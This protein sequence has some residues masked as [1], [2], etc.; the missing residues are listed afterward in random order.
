MSYYKPLDSCKDI[1]SV[2]SLVTGCTKSLSI[3]RCR[4][5]LFLF[6][7]MHWWHLTHWFPKQKKQKL[8]EIRR[9]RENA[10]VLVCSLRHRSN[11]A[12]F[13]L[14]S[15]CFV[16][17]L[18]HQIR[19]MDLEARSLPPSIKSSLLVKL[20][21][22]S[23]LISTTSKAKSRD[24][25]GQLIDWVEPQTE[26]R[27]WRAWRLSPPRLAQSETVFLSYALATRYVLSSTIFSYTGFITKNTT[28]DWHL[29]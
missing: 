23:S 28:C 4:S 26:S 5:S 8:S 12:A 11:K 24:R 3:S 17:F 21:E 7:K 20:R 18:I 10:K 9:G 2:H 14:L 25:W 16:H 1:R 15:L 22:F 27:D 29:F 19:K 6:V 13:Y